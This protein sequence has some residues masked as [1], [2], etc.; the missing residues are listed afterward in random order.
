MELVVPSPVAAHTVPDVEPML[1]VSATAV[2]ERAKVVVLPS[3]GVA[4][5]VSV[6]DPTVVGLKRIVPV[7]Q[8]CPEVKFALAQ[9]PAGTVKSVE[10]VFAKGVAPKLMAPPDAVIVVVPAPQVREAPAPVL[11]QDKD[12]GEAAIVP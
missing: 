9:V 6:F 4:V 12:V 2:P 7:V 10:S 3:V 11:P 5:T 1:I 8:V